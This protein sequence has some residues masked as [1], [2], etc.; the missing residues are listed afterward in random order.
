[1]G[2]PNGNEKP[3]LKRPKQEKS[4]FKRCVTKGQDVVNAREWKTERKRVTTCPR[5]AMVQMLGTVSLILFTKRPF[6]L[7]KWAIPGLFLFI[8]VFS[9]QLT[10][11]VQNFCLWLDS[12]RQPL[13]SEATALPTEPPPLPIFLFLWS[14]YDNL[15]Q[16]C[17]LSTLSHLSHRIFNKLN[18]KWLPSLIT[19]IFWNFSW[20]STV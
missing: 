1:M 2:K 4:G 13:E 10:V 11:D 8:F 15:S 9:I 20:H 5:D 17:M 19:K 14:L 12:N 16:L 18:L 3:R 7:Y 6:H